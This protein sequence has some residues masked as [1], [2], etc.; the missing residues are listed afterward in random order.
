ME[1]LNALVLTFDDFGEVSTN[2][3][4][5]LH[6]G[7]VVACC[8]TSLWENFLTKSGI[9][10][11]QGKLL[12]LGGFCWRQVC[13]EEAFEYFRDFVVSNRLDVLKSLFCRLK[14][15]VSCNF[16]HLREAFETGN[17]LLDLRKLSASF[18]VLF[19]FK[20][21]VPWGCLVQ[22]EHLHS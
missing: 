3:S 22:N 21:T 8:N 15:L 4:Q 12:L 6:G 17:C 11:T 14:R 18:V 7:L 9:A 5:K 13:T 20:Q 10:N 19:F 2:T 16:D 1:C